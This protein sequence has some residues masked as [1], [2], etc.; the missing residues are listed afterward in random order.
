MNNNLD[1]DRGLLDIDDIPCNQDTELSST[2]LNPVEL[3][4]QR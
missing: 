1:E 4:Q 3:K 2:L